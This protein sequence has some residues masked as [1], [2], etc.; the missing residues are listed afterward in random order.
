VFVHRLVL[1]AFSGGDRP[2]QPVDHKNGIRHDNRLENLQWVKDQA[3]NNALA[4]KRRGGGWGP[5]GEACHSAK[6]TA[7]QVL[8]IRALH[9]QGVK[10]AEIARRFGITPQQVSLIILRKRWGHI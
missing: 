9:A 1:A 5:R 3:E 8:K 6:L 2:F 7:A 10:G 4:R